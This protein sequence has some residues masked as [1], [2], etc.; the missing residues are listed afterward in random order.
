[1]LRRKKQLQQELDEDAANLR[2]RIEERQEKIKQG[3]KD[4]GLTEAQKDALLKNI[5]NQLQSL[6]SAYNV[7]QQRQ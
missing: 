7:E 3:N 5:S 6:D 2:A 1:M 4:E